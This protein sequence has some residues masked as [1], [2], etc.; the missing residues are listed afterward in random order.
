MHV[1]VNELRSNIKHHSESIGNWPVVCVYGAHAFVQCDLQI[2]AYSQSKLS[3][4]IIQIGVMRN[5]MVLFECE[6]DEK[7]KNTQK[8]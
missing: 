7:K 8:K 5:K 3:E 6:F 2:S 4:S 1:T